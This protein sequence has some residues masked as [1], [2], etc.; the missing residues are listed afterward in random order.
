MLPFALGLGMLALLLWTAGAFSRANVPTV[1]AFLAWTAALAGILLAAFLLL[2]G[3][4]GAA[5]TGLVLLGP[6]GWSWF[7]ERGVRRGGR[8]GGAPPKLSRAEALEVLGLREGASEA[9][10]REAWVRL[11]RTAH[12][13]SGGSDWLA[14]RVNQARDVLLGRG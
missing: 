7:Q 11:M 3:R 4:G 1:K 9:D 13:D 12:P 8:A 14:A 10:I 5:L 2:T 6:L